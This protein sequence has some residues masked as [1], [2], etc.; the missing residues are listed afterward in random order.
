MI[1]KSN[2]YIIFLE[3]ELLNYINSYSETAPSII[4]RVI[5]RRATFME[6]NSALYE[7]YK[8]LTEAESK[9]VFCGRLGE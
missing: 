5:L 1:W 4:T 8:V 2:Y 6:K 7:R 3:K 9:V